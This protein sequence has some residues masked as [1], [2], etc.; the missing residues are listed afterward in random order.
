M[1]TGSTVFNTLA[2]G[3]GVDIVHIP[4][5][6]EQLQAPGTRFTSVFSAT[7]LRTARRRAGATGALDHHLAARWAGKEA[8]IKAWSL[9]LF[10]QPPA[11]EPERV[12]FSE[13]Q[14]LSDAYGRPYIHL[15]GTIASAFGTS[16]PAAV[17]SLSH[18]GD[19]AIAICQ[20]KGES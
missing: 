3:L 7:E 17:V 12:D 16:R 13:I 15:T 4:A 11:I 10:G 14:V 18:D 20:L 8:F 5:F 2:G 6:A 19:Y 1:R 9:A